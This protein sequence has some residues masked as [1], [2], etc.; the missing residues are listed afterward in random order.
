MH[1]R[2]NIKADEIVNTKINVN[3]T[4]C[5]EVDSISVSLCILQSETLAKTMMNL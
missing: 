1:G 2:K 3:R 4:V 5:K